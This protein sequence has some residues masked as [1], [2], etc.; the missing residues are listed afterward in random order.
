M[1]VTSVWKTYPPSVPVGLLFILKTQLTIAPP[2]EGPP[3][4]P[5]G[6]AMTIFYYTV[7]KYTC[8]G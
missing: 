3:N 8:L 6:Q 2:M 5:K 4:L 1:A 7:M